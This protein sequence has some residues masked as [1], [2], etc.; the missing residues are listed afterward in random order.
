M[1]KIANK[2]RSNRM[3]FDNLI[4]EIAICINVGD[5]EI[6]RELE[7]PSYRGIKGRSGD[8]LCFGSKVSAIGFDTPSD[9]LSGK[10]L[11]AIDRMLRDAKQKGINTKQQIAE[12]IKEHTDLTDCHLCA[13][14]GMM[15]LT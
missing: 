4:K 3:F 14:N 2:C 5:T 7:L 15:S 13:L 1:I 8:S 10:C 9:M 6:N 12:L 11:D